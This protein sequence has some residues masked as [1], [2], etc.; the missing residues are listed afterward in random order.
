[1]IT[2]KY[3]RELFENEKKSRNLQELDDSFLNNIKEYLERKNKLI[4]KTRTSKTVIDY[5]II[6]EVENFKNVLKNLLELRT[7]KIILMALKD[8]YMDKNRDNSGMLDFEYKLYKETRALIEENKITIM[9]LISLKELSSFQ[10][11]TLS[12]IKDFGKEEKESGLDEKKEDIDIEIKEREDN[13]STKE[14]EDGKEEQKGEI[15]ISQNLKYMLQATEEIP[16]FLGMDKNIYGPYMKGERFVIDSK[17]AKILINN[18]KA[19][20]LYEIEINN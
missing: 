20:V 19:K 16:S 1:M 4:E 15:K 13:R 5:S 7:K 2:F 12:K 18:R 10:G 6:N 11:E 8:A 3:I 17:T 14:N 9:D